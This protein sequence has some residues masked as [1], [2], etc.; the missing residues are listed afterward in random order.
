MGHSPA[1][2]H[3]AGCCLLLSVVGQTWLAIRRDI[4]EDEMFSRIAQLRSH[5]AN[6]L[7]NRSDESCDR[8]GDN[9]PLSR[10]ISG[11]ESGNVS[12][13]LNVVDGENP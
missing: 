2:L 11:V 12:L 3:I 1:A 5:G 13:H 10:P 6:D 4:R 7:N 8:K 9:P